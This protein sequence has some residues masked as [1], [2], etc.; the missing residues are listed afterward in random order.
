MESPS[1]KGQEKRQI[2]TTIISQSFNKH[3]STQKTRP[4]NTTLGIYTISKHIQRRIL[5]DSEGSE[6]R[7]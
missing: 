4:N 5:S 1:Y 7:E 2:V 3:T 6:N